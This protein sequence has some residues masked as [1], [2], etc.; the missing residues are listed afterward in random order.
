M[1][2]K[3]CGL[4]GQLKEEKPKTLHIKLHNAYTIQIIMN[5]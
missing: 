2:K 3:S 5:P 4:S 1:N